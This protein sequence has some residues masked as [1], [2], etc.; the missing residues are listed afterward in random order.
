MSRMMVL[1]RVGKVEARREGPEKE[2]IDQN[3]MK[4][5]MN[6]PKLKVTGGIEEGRR[7]FDISDR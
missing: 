7:F 3:I 4:M 6:R 5:M 1:V 2:L